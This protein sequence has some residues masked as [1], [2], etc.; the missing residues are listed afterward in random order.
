MAKSKISY[1]DLP[2]DEKIVQKRRKITRL[3]KNLPSEK[4]QFADSLIYQFCVTAV[5]LERLAD[6]INK[7]EV[8]ENFV[9]G[10]QSLRREN[11]ALKSYNATIKSFTAVSKALLELLPQE[12]QKQVGE[13]LMNFATRPPGAKK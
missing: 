2:I 4:K 11:P 8:I 13:E 3:F 12:T 5:T 7:G 9:Q 6:E 1:D 10:S